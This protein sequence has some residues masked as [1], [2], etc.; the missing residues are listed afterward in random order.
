[1]AGV[2]RRAR[3]RERPQLGRTVT[4]GGLYEPSLGLGELEQNRFV[5][6]YRFSDAT[7]LNRFSRSGTGWRWTITEQTRDKPSSVFADY[8]LRPAPCRGMR[9][10]Y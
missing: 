4:F 10:G 1:M 3:R 6:R 9:F 2:G 5:Q 8:H 7:Y